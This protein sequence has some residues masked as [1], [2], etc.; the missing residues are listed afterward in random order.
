MLLT[1]HLPSPKSQCHPEFIAPAQKI[2]GLA[3]LHLIVVLLYP[4]LKLDLFQL[5]YVLL[6]LV[7]LLPFAQLILIFSVIKNTANRG[8]SFWSNAD[9][10]QVFLTG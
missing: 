1:D 10:V 3:Q 2:D 7:L 6:G 8:N 5:S 9:Q 4:G